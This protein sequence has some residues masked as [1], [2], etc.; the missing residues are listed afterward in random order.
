[1]RNRCMWLPAVLAVIAMLWPFGAVAGETVVITVQRGNNL[2]NICKELLEDPEKWPEVAKINNI[3][4]PNLI[5]PGSA[6]TVPV[7]LLK[8]IPIVGRVER[9]HGDAEIRFGKG[10]KWN[11]LHKGDAVSQGNSIRTGEY[12]DAVIKYD[13]GSRLALSANTTITVSNAVEKRKAGLIRN[14]FLGLGRAVMKIKGG[15]RS[16]VRTPT[17]VLGIRGTEFRAVSLADETARAEVLNSAVAVS[18]NE[19]A[20]DVRQGEGTVVKKDGQPADPVKLL[21]PPKPVNVKPLFEELPVQVGF[22]KIDG[23]VSYRVLLYKDAG[24]AGY[25]VEKIIKSGDTYRISDLPDGEYWLR[26]TSI[27]KLGLEGLP[28]DLIPVRIKLAASI[29]PPRIETARLAGDTAAIS[30]NSLG[31]GVSYRF[32]LARDENFQAV[33]VDR[34]TDRTQMDVPMPK[35]PGAYFARIIGIDGLKRNRAFS[36]HVKFEVGEPARNPILFLADVSGSMRKKVSEGKKTKVSVMKDLLIDIFT[37]L[38][39]NACEIGIYRFRY[40]SGNKEICRPFTQIGS[41]KQDEML[42]KISKEFDTDYPVF[43]RRTPIADMLRKLDETE[44]QNLDGKVTA[45]LVSDGAESFYDLGK[46]EKQK[47]GDKMGRVAGP[48]S[49]VRRIREKYGEEFVLHT[50]FMDNGE[51]EGKT[52]LEKIAEATGGKSF[53]GLELANDRS[54]VAELCA[55]ICPTPVPAAMPEPVKAMP[56]PE[57]PVVLPAVEKK[58]PADDDNDG[59]PNDA[60]ACPRTAGGIPVDSKGC[61]KDSDGDGVSDHED[62]CPDTPAGVKPDAF[63]C[64][65][66]GV[67]FPTGKWDIRP[68]SYPELDAVVRILE[69]NPGLKLEI[70]GHT[71]NVGTEERNRRLSEK[72]A[73]A[74]MEYLLK[75]GISKDRLTSAGY[76]ETKPAVSNATKEGRAI[77]RRVEL[78][79]TSGQ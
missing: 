38:P 45:V 77:N 7:K 47:P 24:M 2:I 54:K 57:P 22:E 6:L 52:L 1:M 61:P 64:W 16:E 59:V 30:W 58:A 65:I 46:D 39:E 32:Q 35:T 72:R 76:G 62:R 4:D 8:G 69:K 21:P 74:V 9:I 51:S 41:M 15:T 27:D 56:E 36:V 79:V 13:D 43:N 18:A 14:F 25:P 71:D 19:K 44:L 12:S 28:S 50:I 49:E 5:R 11:R 60:D 40:L 66:P 29:S 20:V 10:L 48:L 17:A 70:Q 37:E 3:P 42:E 68:D 73:G 53:D 75:K 34:E 67:R 26:V 31:P 33:L 78:A 63:G 55:L 23:A